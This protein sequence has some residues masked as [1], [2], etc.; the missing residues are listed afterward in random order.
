VDGNDSAARLLE[1][2]DAALQMFEGVD[3]ARTGVRPAPGK[4]CA[5]EVLGHLMDDYVTHLRHHLG[6]IRALLKG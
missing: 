6:Q 3:E 5:R 4:W 1:T 2:V